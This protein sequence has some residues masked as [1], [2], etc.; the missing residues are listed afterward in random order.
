MSCEAVT[1]FTPNLRLVRRC[2]FFWIELTWVTRAKS[3][4]CCFKCV[5]REKLLAET[6]FE[7]AWNVLCTLDYGFI[8]FMAI[9]GDRGSISSFGGAALVCARILRSWLPAEDGRVYRVTCVSLSRLNRFSGETMLLDLG[10]V[11]SL[12]SII[13]ELGYWGLDRVYF[14]EVCAGETPALIRSIL[15]GVTAPAALLRRGLDIIAV[16]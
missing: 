5:V 15:I 4:D 7:R 1:S 2:F 9:F 11:V 8:L 12:F 16:I 14:T 13:C 6:D 10:W 3:F